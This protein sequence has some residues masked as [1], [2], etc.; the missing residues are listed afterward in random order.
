[1]ILIRR[2][3]SRFYSTV[4][5]IL[6]FVF[7]ILDSHHLDLDLDRFGRIDQTVEQRYFCTLRL[8]TLR[9]AV[10]FITLQGICDLDDCHGVD[11]GD[12]ND[13]IH[14]HMLDQFSFS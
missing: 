7:I 6:R 1:M 11:E 12:H 5:L 8:P 4:R 2:T 13:N 9:A 14:M 3:W 10:R